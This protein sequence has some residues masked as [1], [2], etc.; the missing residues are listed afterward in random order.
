MSEL[1]G[2]TAGVSFTRSLC[3]FDRN[4][5]A[6]NRPKRDNSDFEISD[7][8]RDTDNGDALGNTSGDMK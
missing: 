7:P 3:D 2:T 6:A 1:L 5:T 8:H 4:D